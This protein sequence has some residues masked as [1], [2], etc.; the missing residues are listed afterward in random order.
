[1]NWKGYVLQ[2]V[3]WPQEDKFI[4]PA[5]EQNVTDEQIAECNKKGNKRNVFHMLKIPG[6]IAGVKGIAG[7]GKE[8]KKMA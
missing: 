2:K 6:N 5:K 1:M 8:N 4:I 3:P 7:H